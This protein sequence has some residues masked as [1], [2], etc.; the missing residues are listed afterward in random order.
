MPFD[1]LIFYLD[2]LAIMLVPCSTMSTALDSFMQA[3]AFVSELHLI[4][5]KIYR[6]GGV[7]ANGRAYNNYNRYKLRA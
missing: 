2:I 4:V 5:R 6:S 1:F 3:R 7:I